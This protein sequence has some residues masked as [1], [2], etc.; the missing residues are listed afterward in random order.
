MRASKLW[1]EWKSRSG[2][3]RRFPVVPARTAFLSVWAAAAVLLAP[4]PAG[5]QAP[6]QSQIASP[7]ASA[8]PTP[9]ARR[10]KARAPA[11][12]SIMPQLRSCLSVEDMSKERLQCYDA[13]VTP[14]PRKTTK[15]AVSVRDCRFVQEED[16]RITCFNRFVDVPEKPKAKAKARRRAKPP[17]AAPATG[18]APPS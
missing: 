18:A 14:A 5:A 8:P 15:K 9:K 3:A 7:E 1:S 2:S 13:V 6:A 16:E 4:I 12:A 17:A 10:S 11:Q